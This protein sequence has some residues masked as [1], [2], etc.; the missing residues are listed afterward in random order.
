MNPT[1]FVVDDF[2]WNAYRYK[3][4]AI[5]TTPPSEYCAV[6]GNTRIATLMGSAR[7]VAPKVLFRMPTYVDT[8]EV[9]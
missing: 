3:A 7:M 4:D 8:E 6:R 1:W 9:N 2:R 5:V